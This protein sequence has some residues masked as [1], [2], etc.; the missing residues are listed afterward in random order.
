VRHLLRVGDLARI[1]LRAVEQG[2]QDAESVAG[3]SQHVLRLL[4]LFE[5]GPCGL[6]PIRVLEEHGVLL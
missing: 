2:E 6:S 3:V 5:V 1:Q 4:S